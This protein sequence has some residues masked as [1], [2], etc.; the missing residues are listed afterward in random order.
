M[1]KTLVFLLMCAMFLSSCKAKDDK[2]LV[3]ASESKS[4]TE[5]AS[6]AVYRKIT[7]EEAREIMESTENYILLDVRTEEEYKDKRIDGATLIPGSE[8][9]DR[10][11]SELSDKD[12]VIFVYCR[13]G[14]RSANA[15]KEL[16]GMGYTCVY[17]IGGIIDWPY[18][19]VSG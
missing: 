8:I 5:N 17:D 12:A 18:K 9:A 1:I 16:V 4:M 19:T 6:E 2:N 7:A 14:V 3:P 11:E 15:A 10:A 13:S